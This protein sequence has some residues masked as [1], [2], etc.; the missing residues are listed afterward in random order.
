MPLFFKRWLGLVPGLCCAALCWAQTAPYPFNFAYLNKDNGLPHNYCHT[1]LRDHRGFL[2]FGT[3]DGLARFDGVRFKIYAAHDDATGLSAPTVLDLEEDPN[4]YIWIATIGGGLNRFDPVTETFQWYRHDSRDPSSLPG[5]DL[6]N[7]LI[8]R[9][10]SIWVGAYNTGFSRLDTRTGRCQNMNLAEHL[11]IEEDRYRR[12]SVQ[13]IAADSEDPAVL[14][15][16]AND[17]IFRYDKRSGELRRFPSEAPCRDVQAD[18]PGFVWV[19]TDGGGIARFEK[20]TARWTFF[21]PLPAEWARRNLSTNLISDISRKSEREFWVASLDL[22]FGI[23]DIAS[24]KYTFFNSQAKL[25]A[26]QTSQSANGLYRDPAGLLWIFNDKNGVSLLD[27]ASNVLDYTPLPSEGCPNPRLN[28]PQAFAWNNSR[29]EL[30]VVTEG[31]GGLYVYRPVARV[32][33]VQLSGQSPYR[34]ERQVLPGSGAVSLQCLLPDRQGR[35]WVGAQGGGS[36]FYEF[37]PA[38]Q[39][40]KAFRHRLLASVPLH[41]FAVNALAED[42][43]GRIWIGTTKGGLFCYDVPR[44]TLFQILKKQ[45]FDGAHLQIEDLICDPSGFI[46]MATQEAGVFRYDP[47]AGQFV[48]Y[49]H[50][51]GSA[52]GL[53]EDRVYCLAADSAGNIWV[54]TDSQGLQRIPAGA[55]PDAVFEQFTRKDGLAFN[56]IH[57]LAS[58][59]DGTLWIATEKGMSAFRPAGRQFETFDE[60]D[61]LADTYLSR[62]G[63]GYCSNGELFIGQAQGFYSFR[64]GTAYQNRTPPVL[65]FTGMQLFGRPYFTGKDLNYLP[66]LRLHHDQN[67]FILQ[68]AALSLSQ[69][70]RNQY[71]YQMEGIDPGW[72]N[73]GNRTEASYTQVPPGRYRFRVQARN[74]SGVASATELSLWVVLE[75]AFYQTWWFRLILLALVLTAIVWYF[76]VRLKEILRRAAAKNELN[77]LRAL[78]AEFEN[79]ALRAQMNPHFI[80]NALNTIEALIVEEKP[81]AASALLQKFSKLMRLVLE[82]SRQPRVSLALELQA[83]ELYIQLEAIR[84]DGR[85]RY[86]IDLSPE[87]EPTRCQVPP[88][89]LQPYVENAVL[90]G[91]RHLREREGLLLVRIDAVELPDGAET[92]QALR[93]CIEDNGIGRPASAHINQRTQIGGKKQSLGTQITAER[94]DLLNAAGRQDYRVTIEDR[95]EEKESGTRVTLLL[96]L[97]F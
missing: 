44:D 87:L 86:Q 83:L 2:W 79:K 20:K 13:D 9:D 4:G 31:C 57:R 82:N 70:N 54:G 30:Y 28:E 62:K 80:F 88:M 67:F 66:E 29:Q 51:P 73:N 96:P 39:R 58:G 72:I 77:R 85:F 69:A 68:F 41:Q 93:C 55:G 50:R 36:T 22:G 27:P 5:N 71:W 43:R 92:A 42:S 78:K 17:G 63:L 48:H 56:K 46:W 34:L 26:G 45:D 90:H 47:A 65:A 1:A 74:S 89:I 59:P 84:M 75:P 38:Q 95:D 10:G 40:L 76:R 16:A 32:A 14:W 60:S 91:L 35:Y 19:A 7:L 64:P 25:L 12:N 21:P 15:L 8:D 3:Q 52:S 61:G 6:T 97:E 49:A 18:T 94:I 11:G 37:L 33:P 81:D 53:A 24:G 23:F